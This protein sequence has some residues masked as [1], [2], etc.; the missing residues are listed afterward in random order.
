M[1][2][3]VEKLAAN[4]QLLTGQRVLDSLFPYLKMYVEGKEVSIVERTNSVMNT[5][6]M[7]VA[8]YLTLS[9]YFRHMGDYVAMMANSTS[10]WSEALRKSCGRL[11]ETSANSAYPTH[12]DTRLASFYERPARVRC[13]DNPE[14]EDYSKFV[15]LHAKCKEILQEEADL[16]D[17]VQLVGRAS[18]AQTDK[19]TL[20]VARIIM[21]DFIQQNGY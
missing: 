21:D 8:D 7:P 20:D 2:P 18:L 4:H 3:V 13:L 17:I 10:P 19:I 12:L 9:E 1:R 11:A 14:R 5:S 6:N 15:T 16:S